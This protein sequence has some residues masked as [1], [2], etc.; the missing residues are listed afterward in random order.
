MPK[1]FKVHPAALAFPRMHKAEFDELKADIAVHG[2]RLPILV[3]SKR[4]TIF[5]GRNRIMAAHDLKLP[6]N[7]IPIEVFTGSDEEAVAAIISRNI[8]RRHLTD[9]QRVSIVAKLFGLKSTQTRGR[10]REI[11]AAEAKV[12]DYKARAA[13][14]AAKHSPKD[15]DRVIAG[16]EKLSEAKKKARAKAGKTAKP[17]PEKSLRERIEAKFLRFMESF[18]VAEYRKVRAILRELLE[19]ADR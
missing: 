11:V 1:V 8:M 19:K 17:K 12:G 2:I 7:K 14:S 6:D 18:A 3:N 10:T 4:D 5:D 16:K 13:L 9:D 15:L